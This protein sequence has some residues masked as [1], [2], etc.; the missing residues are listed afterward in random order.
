MSWKMTMIEPTLDDLLADD[1]MRPVLR[2]AGV[3]AARL[4]ASL[5]EAAR[6]LGANLNMPV[7]HKN[8]SEAMCC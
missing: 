4:R 6:R 2:S 1:I 3:D 8:C 5:A 7:H